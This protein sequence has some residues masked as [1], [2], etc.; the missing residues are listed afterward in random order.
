MYR[1]ICR[2]SFS[3]SLQRFVIISVIY[4]IHL[5]GLKFQ[6]LLTILLKKQKIKGDFHVKRNNSQRNTIP[7]LLFFFI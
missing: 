7:N 1:N 4:N 2:V 5:K 3:C 6:K